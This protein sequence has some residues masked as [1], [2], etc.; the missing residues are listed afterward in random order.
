MEIDVPGTDEKDATSDPTADDTKVGQT[1]K[2]E[3]DG[4]NNE[5]NSDI[6]E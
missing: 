5:G 3:L 1:G 6:T 2:D 4:P